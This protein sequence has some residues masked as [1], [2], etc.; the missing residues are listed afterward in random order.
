MTSNTDSAP[1][2]VAPA[3]VSEYA[4]IRRD[5]CW[6]HE[7]N[8]N[9]KSNETESL[10]AIDEY[11][12]R[13]EHVFSPDQAYPHHHALI[14]SA[15]RSASKLAMLSR[16]SVSATPS[17]PSPSQEAEEAELRACRDQVAFGV[18]DIELRRSQYAATILHV[19]LM[20][21]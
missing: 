5:G 21:C 18:R 8:I 16:S 15:R 20:C 11:Y 7:W 10:R 13:E 12:A 6:P 3:P 14:Q 17:P 4:T 19:L 9:Q 1:A 2:S